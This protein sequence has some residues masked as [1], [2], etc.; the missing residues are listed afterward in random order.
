MVLIRI[1][2]LFPPESWE[3]DG[4]ADAYCNLDDVEMV[5]LLR[6]IIML[7]TFENKERCFI[8]L[9]E[10]GLST[11]RGPKSLCYSCQV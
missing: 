6:M 1:M 5:K 11:S 8:L 9:H 10:N 3:I 2:P 4:E 7:M